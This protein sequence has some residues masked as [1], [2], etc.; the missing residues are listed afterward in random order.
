MTNRR[1]S[2]SAFTL[3]EVLIAVTITILVVVMLANVFCSL[4]AT[5][6]RA[7]QR[8]DAFRDARAALK[9][10]ERDMTN[11]VRAVPTAHFALADRYSDPNTATVKNRQLYGLTAIK[12]GLG[13]LCAVGYYCRW[14]SAKQA[15]SLR[16]YFKDSTTT[17]TTLK[18]NGAGIYAPVSK[19]F[20]PGASDETIA[21]YIWNLQITAYKTDGT[22]DNTYP[23]IINPSNPSAVLPAAI[24][25]SFDAI[26][27]QAAQAMSSVSS[28]PNDWMD[29]TTTNYQRLIAPYMYEFR[30]RIN[31]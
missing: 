27:P 21:A 24:E 29:S 20:V 18:S 12:N 3:L 15:Y 11:L 22:V 13:D 16:R 1:P 14:D 25:V 9:M 7:N 23:L 28:T 5:S 31:F 10:I 30:S 6:A 8:I 2:R 19:L 26:S 17:L 4:T